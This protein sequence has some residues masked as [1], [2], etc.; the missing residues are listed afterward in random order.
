MPDTGAARKH[1][2]NAMPTATLRAVCFS[3]FTGVAGVPWAAHAQDAQQYPNRPLRFL[4]GFAAGGFTD[5]M[6]RA[7]AAKL[8]DNWSQQV[9]V[10]NRPGAGTIVAT[11]LAAK[12]PPDGYTLLMMTDNFV[13]NPSLFKQLPYD[14]EKDFAPITLGA[15]A[16]LHAA[17]PSVTS[18]AI[19]ERARR[20]RQGAA[21]AAAVRIGRHRRAGASRRRTFEYARRGAHG[22]RAVQRRRAGDDR[23]A[24]G[25]D[26]ALL[27]Q[28]ADQP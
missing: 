16:P 21:G 24:G 2:E 14:S 18:R 9:V 17:R 25:A 5:V 19:R 12:S 28:P 13:T 22:A 10:D 27:R 15:L 6:A 1:R 7:I 8:A 23:S 3:A 4:V 11:D 26:P 20:A